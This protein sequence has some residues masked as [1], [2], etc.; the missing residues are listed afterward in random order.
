MSS[1]LRNF[2]AGLSPRERR[3]V[4]AMAATAVLLACFL[5]GFVLHG[6][7]AELEAKSAEW[8]E[9][10]KFV[11]MMEPKYLELQAA[12]PAVQSTGRPTPLRPPV[13]N[14]VKR[15]GIDEPDTKELNDKNHASGWIE[16]SVDVSFRSIPLKP[17][18]DFMEQ[19]EANRRQFP[20]AISRLDIRDLKQEESLYRVE[21]TIATYEKSTGVLD[22][23]GKPV[24][25]RESRP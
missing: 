24:D 6:A 1:I 5:T 4:L 25:A 22:K 14:I 15:V 16:R 12:G 11:R 9:L 8:T 17:L 10:V 2:M 3:L 23:N 20:I 18:V 19:V 7:T 13:D 21:M